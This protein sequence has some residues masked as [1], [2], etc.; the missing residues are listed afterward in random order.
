MDTSLLTGLS[1]ICS[2]LSKAARREGTHCLGIPSRSWRGFRH[3][4]VS[5]PHSQ[6]LAGRSRRGHA[7]LVI[8]NSPVC[9]IFLSPCKPR[10]MTAGFCLMWIIM[11][12]ILCPGGTVVYL[13]VTFSIIPCCGRQGLN[14][15][16]G[17]PAMPLHPAEKHGCL[18]LYESLEWRCW[19]PGTG[20]QHEVIILWA[21]EALGSP[22]IGP[23]WVS[24]GSSLKGIE[25]RVLGEVCWKGKQGITFNQNRSLYLLLQKHPGDFV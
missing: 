7:I 9:Y 20:D 21:K 5:W 19:N 24:K 4:S 22:L 6:R 15:H 16:Q 2:A 25:K 12:L 14:T 18:Q 13:H 1:P 10:L 11:T 17:L 8:I 3:L 23:L